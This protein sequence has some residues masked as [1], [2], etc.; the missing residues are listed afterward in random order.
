VN[1]TF[2]VIE[3]LY[4]D[5]LFSHVDSTDENWL[6]IWTTKCNCD[7]PHRLYNQI[8]GYVHRSRIQDVDELPKSKRK[9]LFFQIFDTELELFNNFLT[10]TDRNSK[11]Y[12]RSNGKRKVFHD[13][14][15]DGSLKP[16]TSVVSSFIYPTVFPTVRRL[17][18]EKSYFQ[19]CC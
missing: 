9:L 12:Q 5:E 13:Y 7:I 15:F 2:E 1:A 10:A 8:E 19:L 18:G 3:K 4:T 14:Q 11:E 6:K 17:D 16:Y